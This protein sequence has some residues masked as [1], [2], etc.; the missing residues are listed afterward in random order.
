M[1]SATPEGDRSFKFERLFSQFE[2]FPGNGLVAGSVEM[3]VFVFRP[4][5]SVNAI[6][7]NAEEL[8]QHQ[9]YVPV[10][11]REN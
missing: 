2:F 10:F 4:S 5:E 11:L 1:S 7:H 8:I 9:I 3:H 6:R